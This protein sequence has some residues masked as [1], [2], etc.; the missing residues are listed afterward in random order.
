[1]LI[2]KGNQDTYFDPNSIF[3]YKRFDES[4]LSRVLQH[5]KNG[6][7][8]I[9]SDRGELKHE[10]GTKYTDEE[11]AKANAENRKKL[12]NDLRRNGLGY[13]ST[14]GGY[15][16]L[17]PN[18]DRR[19][20][21]DEQSKFVPYP[22]EDKMSFD[23]FRKFG[24]ELAKKYQQDS[25]L[26]AEPVKDKDGNTVGLN[27]AYW[28]H[29]NENDWNYKQGDLKFTNIGFDKMPD[30]YSKLKKGSHAGR[31]FNF[32]EGID[33]DIDFELWGY[34]APASHN[35]RILLSFSGELLY[36]VKPERACKFTETSEERESAVYVNDN[37]KK[38]FLDN[39]VEVVKESRAVMDGNIIHLTNAQGYIRDFTV[40]D[41]SSMSR[42]LQHCKNGFFAISACRGDRDV[43]AGDY[44]V[45][46]LAG[47]NHTNIKNVNEIRKATPE[48][49][50]KINNIWTKRLES[51]IRGKGLGFI[52]T[53]GGYPETAEDGSVRFIDDEVSKFVPYKAD[54]MSWDDFVKFATSL[55]SEFDQDSVA[56]GEPVKGE[57]LLDVSLWAHPADSWD[58]KPEFNWKKIEFPDVDGIL[59]RL[60]NAE[61]VFYSR[62]K[63]GSHS[64][65]K[66]EY[67]GKIYGTVNPASYKAK[68]L[69]SLSG[70]ILYNILPL[71]N[72]EIFVATEAVDEI[73][74]DTPIDEAVKKATKKFKKG[75]GKK[76]NFEDDLV[77]VYDAETGEQIYSGLEDYEGMKDEP[78]KWDNSL[79]AYRLEADVNG[80][81]YSYIKNC[82]D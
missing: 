15:G 17:L 30:Y 37:C 6:F 8:A 79:G 67:A 47:Y 19:F 16:E 40:L 14:L 45:E 66:F 63:K 78:W 11:L 80:K 56:I 2:I 74:N 13:I 65:K 35:G 69:M 57:E 76:I 59:K 20:V 18:G 43:P 49:N 29:P 21:D 52:T 61:L 9:S 41:E 39:C 28:E 38:W 51:E 54:V 5:C 1:M 27:A 36:G 44:S 53:W 68:Q 4:S 12:E 50:E 3:V 82:V 70:E 42:I 10:D 34:R 75:S 26:I 33:K 73:L 24:I 62:L 55:A 22:G 71:P 81:H 25:V 77:V 7:M 60:K 31:K 48:E 72:Q 64:G 58:Y 32:K 23:Q 46:Q